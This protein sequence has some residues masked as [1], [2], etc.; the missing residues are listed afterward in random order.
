VPTL[1][2]FETLVGTDVAA[3]ISD[4]DY[5]GSASGS[6]IIDLST[7]TRYWSSS[8]SNDNDRNA[9]S[10][11]FFGFG[12]MPFVSNNGSKYDGFQVRCVK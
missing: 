9:Y 7:R 6:G 1:Q 2:D 12:G 5:G 8:E 11:F 4:W 10:L 3:L